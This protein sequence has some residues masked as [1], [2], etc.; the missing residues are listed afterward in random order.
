MRLSRLPTAPTVHARRPQ[1]PNAAAQASAHRT[2]A[3]AVAF[4]AAGRFRA[5]L[6]RVAALLRAAG[7]GALPVELAIFWIMSFDVYKL[8]PTIFLFV[9]RSIWHCAFPAGC[10]Y[11]IFLEIGQLIV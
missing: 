8:R 1:H 11:S 10:F 4:R 7:G 3:R 2:V 6:A 9:F 5:G